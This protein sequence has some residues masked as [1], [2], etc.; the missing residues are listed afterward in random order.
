MR[1]GLRYALDRL[2]LAAG[3]IA[4]G[5]IVLICLIVTVQV[6]FNLTARL[7]GPEY[8]WTIPSYADFAGFL[9]AGATFLALAHTLV[10]GGHIRVNLL[11]S[12]L[13]LPLAFMAEL[14]A[15][16]LGLAF[17]LFASWHMAALVAE[18]WR[19]GDKSPGI[20]PVPLWLPQ[21]VVTLGLVILAIAFADLLMQA[22]RARRPILREADEIG[23]EMIEVEPGMPDTASG[24]ASESTT[25][26]KS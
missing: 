1:Q 17:S 25:G 6:L 18:S 11:A 7:L 20:V 13:P 24:G 26:G 3:W 22:I 5:A 15:L 2:Y 9:L 14:F 10:E 21:A 16:A 23:S 8:S 19:Y 12:R 4:A